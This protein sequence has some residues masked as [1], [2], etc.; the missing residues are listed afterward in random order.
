MYAEVRLL[1]VNL[2]VVDFAKLDLDGDGYW[3]R[4]ESGQLEENYEGQF[5]RRANVR[6][7]VDTWDSA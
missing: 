3:T 4:T 6:A 1:Q 5:N 7:N 2:L